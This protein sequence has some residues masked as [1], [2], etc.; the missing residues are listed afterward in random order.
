MAHFVQ[1]NLV[2]FHPHPL[3]I[4]F[5]NTVILLKYKINRAYQHFVIIDTFYK[6]A[7]FV[8][9]EVLDVTTYNI[10]SLKPIGANFTY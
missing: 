3:G 7:Y 4:I 2:N 8:L 10:K 9:T 6:N 5:K 1:C